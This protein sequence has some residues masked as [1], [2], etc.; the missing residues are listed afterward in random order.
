VSKKVTCQPLHPNCLNFN[1]KIAQNCRFA[2]LQIM[3]G[4]GVKGSRTPV[5]EVSAQWLTVQ[6]QARLVRK[7][8]TLMIA[9]SRQTIRVI[10]KMQTLDTTK[11]V[12]SH[13][14]LTISS[15]I[16]TTRIS[17]SIAPS[18]QQLGPSLDISSGKTIAPLRHVGKPQLE[19]DKMAKNPGPKDQLQ[20]LSRIQTRLQKILFAIELAT[21]DRR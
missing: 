4:A 8:C 16:T 6:L 12:S 19:R 10:A 18:R 17:G 9:E 14:Q 21:I 1:A 5:I 20:L 13:S 2:R 11:T 15:I 7:T 3:F